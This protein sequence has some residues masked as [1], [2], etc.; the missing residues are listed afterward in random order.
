MCPQG[1]MQYVPLVFAFYTRNVGRVQAKAIT[2][3][4]LKARDEGVDVG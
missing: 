1:G 3:S 4:L 2:G